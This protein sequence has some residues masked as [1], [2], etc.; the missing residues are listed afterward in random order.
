MNKR[1]GAATLRQRVYDALEHGSVEDRTSQYI[2]RAIVALIVVSLV[3]ASLETVPSLNE[4]WGW[5]FDV[6]ETVALIVFTVE[7]GLRLWVAPEHAPMQ[8]LS[9][10]QARWRYAVSGAGLVDLLAVLPFWFAFVVPPDLRVVLV[11]RIIRFLKLTRYSPAMRSLLDALNAERRAL[12]GCLVILVG[13]TLVAAAAMH[14]VE[15]HA[16]PEKFGTIPDAMWWAIVTLGTI[17]YGDAVPVTALGRL[18]AAFTIFGGLIMVALPVGIVAT[19]FAEEIHR[20]DFVVTWSM[21]ARVPLFEGLSASDIADVMKLLRAETF[22]SGE[23][24]VRRGEPAHSMYFIAAGAVDITLPD[25]VKQMHAG[26]FFG[27][28]AILRRARRSATVTAL[29]RCNLLVLEA[30]DFRA[31]MER[32]EGVMERMRK[33]TR[34]RL[35]R[36]LVTP[37]GDIVT[38]ELEEDGRAERP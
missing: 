29:T 27:E 5:A 37:A 34:D 14:I 11:A 23:V 38:E 18:I 13:A 26:H 31:L 20:R 17:G 19:A 2:S 12:F 30:R 33:I 8:H 24:I 21:V 15:R 32:H 1:S 16:Q 35:G 10:V 36:E 4:R 28:V 7:Y 6:V 25:G 9:A 3:A 22:E